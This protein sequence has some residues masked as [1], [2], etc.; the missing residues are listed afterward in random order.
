VTIVALALGWWVDRSRL[1][2]RMM[3]QAES[4]RERIRWAK[5][6]YEAMWERYKDCVNRPR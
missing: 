5:L 1:E 6:D 4:D 3:R 2:D